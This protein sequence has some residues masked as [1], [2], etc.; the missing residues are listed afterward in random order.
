ME[1]NKL[2]N[3]NLTLLIK[4][5]QEK[6]SNRL[7]LKKIE[8]LKNNEYDENNF[9]LSEKMEKFMEY[10]NKTEEE[11]KIE[12]EEKKEKAK[13]WWICKQCEYENEINSK[14]CSLCGLYK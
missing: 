7:N 6:E 12:E 8:K 2:A 5:H 9:N 1:M 14:Q 3:Y 4:N 10:L 11:K 13:Q